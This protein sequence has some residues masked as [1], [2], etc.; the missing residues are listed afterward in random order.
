M[1]EIWKDIPGYEGLYQVSNIG[2][3]KSLDRTVNHSKFGVVRRTGKLLALCVNS[4]GYIVVI[5][6]KGAKRMPCF[7]HRLVATAFLGEHEGMEV[8]HID[9]DRANN[10]TDNLE[11]VTHLQNMHH[12]GLQER[13]QKTLRKKPVCA[14]DVSGHLVHSFESVHEA[15]RNGFN[16]TA[17]S[18]VINRRRKTHGGYVW[19]VA[20]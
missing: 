2:R 1:K 8:N 7:V 16:D 3:V 11:W 9:C 14:Y 10:R 5:L 19:K 18:A 12:N 15:G 6:Y 13:V 20:E 17:I 4:K